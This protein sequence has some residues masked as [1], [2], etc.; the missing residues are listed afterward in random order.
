MNEKTY[1]S[2]ALCH[3]C[4]EIKQYQVDAFGELLENC[5][6]ADESPIEHRYGMTLVEIIVK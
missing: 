6:M 5:K 2:W 4:Q 1:I 3:A